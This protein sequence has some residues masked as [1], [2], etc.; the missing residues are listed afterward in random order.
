MH[1]D[2]PT[3]VRIVALKETASHE[4]RVAIT[5]DSAKKF[6]AL[7]AE[8]TVESGAGLASGYTDQAYINAGAQI[9]A[10][11]SLQ[12]ATLVLCVQR[13]AIPLPENTILLG[14]LSPHAGAMPG[15]NDFA[16]ERLPRI[17]RAQSMDALSSQ[18][19]LAGYRAVIEAISASAKATPMLMTAAGTVA[20]SRALVL[21]AGVAG[22]QAI[23]TAKRLGA[24]V[25]AFDVR[26]SA[27]EQVESLGAKFIA[28]EG[29][30]QDAAYAQETSADYQA[31]QAALIHEHIVKQ[32]FVITTA[33]IPGK[34]APRLISE[35]MV[36]AMKHGAVI[37]D[38]AAGSG[39]NCEL[40]QANAA[41]QAHGV[42]LI[43]HTNLP[44][45]VSLDASNL[46]ARNLFNFASTLLLPE[47]KWDDE[48]IKATHLSN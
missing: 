15:K 14:L 33:L 32:D 25:T 41:T 42:T 10:G 6:I 39:G 3:P 7:G 26:A 27:K 31:R 37:V 38:M 12:N 46:Y 9:A 23:A 17:S 30:A 1:G 13:P 18:A 36:K 45:R 21:G 22:L 5:P 4:A 40:T 29:E 24:I 8:V 16:L 2:M 34:P 48:L 19:N 20:P 44:S 47:V 11:D 35:A 43:G 28:V